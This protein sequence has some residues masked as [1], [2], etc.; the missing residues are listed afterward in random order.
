MG[1]GISLVSLVTDTERD[2]VPH[3][4]V[5][6]PPT[7]TRAGV[8][9]LPGDAGKLWGA[10]RV[11]DTLRPTVGRGANHVGETGALAPVPNY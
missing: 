5:S 11:Q 1:E 2:V 3:P 8:Q 7:Q 10:V 6:P 4:T 9:A